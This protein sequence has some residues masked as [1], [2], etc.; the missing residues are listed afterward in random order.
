MNKTKIINEF[1]VQN[2]QKALIYMIWIAI[3]IIPIAVA[4]NKNSKFR[5][6]TFLRLKLSLDFNRSIV[7]NMI[8]NEIPN[9]AIGT[10]NRFP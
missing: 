10:P 7:N 2:G 9:A 1:K 3:K 8:N 5:F 6:V 4:G